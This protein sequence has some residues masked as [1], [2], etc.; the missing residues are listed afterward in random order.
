M[1]FL[2]IADYKFESDKWHFLAFTYDGI[3]QQG[4]FVIDDTYGYEGFEDLTNG[5][6]NVPKY[7]RKIKTQYTQLNVYEIVLRQCYE[8]IVE[9][10]LFCIDILRTIVN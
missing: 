3:L 7:V 10:E 6:K 9:N 8:W 4:T 2:F 5:T 1:Y